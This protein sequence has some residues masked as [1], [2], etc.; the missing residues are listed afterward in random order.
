MGDCYGIAEGEDL[1][2]FTLE[3][4]AEVVGIDKE[5]ACDGRAFWLITN[6]SEVH[7]YLV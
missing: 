5:A 7:K 6:K 3:G 4:V 2:A 1:V